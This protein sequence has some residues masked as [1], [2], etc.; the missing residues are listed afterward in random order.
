VSTSA[1][2]ETH[3]NTYCTNAIP[4]LHSSSPCP[5]SP[6]SLLSHC[7]WPRRSRDAE[8]EQSTVVAEKQQPL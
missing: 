1:V 4:A 5:F 6:P 7:C 3:G 2:V 8:L